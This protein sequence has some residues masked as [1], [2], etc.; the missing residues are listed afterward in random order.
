MKSIFEDTTYNEILE[1]LNNLT[2]ETTPQWGK[3]NVGQMLAHCHAPLE[4]GLGKSTLPPASFFKRL[5]FKSFKTSLYNDKPW[6]K[7]LRTT[8]EY[9]I[10]NERDFSTEKNAL[11]ALID[12]FHENKNRENWPVHPF[13]GEFTTAQWGKLQYK[14]LDH[15]FRQ[16]NV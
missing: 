8:P 9:K 15:H 1:R 16:F 12:E 6:R 14:H 10:T 2:K 4:V 7:N 5:L 11:R 3:M 13:F